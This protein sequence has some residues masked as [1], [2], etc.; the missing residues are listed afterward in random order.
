MTPIVR[1]IRLDAARE[2]NRFQSNP[3][4]RLTL[5]SIAAGALGIAVVLALRPVGEPAVKA[6]RAPTT[7]PATLQHAHDAF[8]QANWDLGAE[9]ATVPLYQRTNPET[10]EAIPLRADQQ[11]IS[12][13]APTGLLESEEIRSG[14]RLTDP[15]VIVGDS[16][17]AAAQELR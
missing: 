17:G 1:P 10:G 13:D 4:M 12:A 8:G 7:V 2:G 6:A 3:P 15:H 16:E 14:E 11:E 9:P 5:I